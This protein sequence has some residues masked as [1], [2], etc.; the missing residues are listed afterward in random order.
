MRPLKNLLQSHLLG[1]EYY[2]DRYNL[3][4]GI[5]EKKGGKC[6]SEKYVNVATK[7]EFECKEG[8]VWATTP[9]GIIKGSWC[10]VCGKKKTVEPQKNDF[11]EIK[12]II[13]DKGGKC[14]TD[15]YINSLQKLDVMCKEG[16][17][18][19]ISA[20][21]LKKGSWCV[22]CGIERAKE[23][24]TDSI[25]IYHKIAEEYEGKC[26]S[27]KYVNSRTK[28]KFECKN[29]HVWEAEPHHIKRNHWCKLC[30]NDN[31]KGR[32]ITFQKRYSMEEV[33]EIAVS[34]GGKCLSEKV[35]D[36][37]LDFICKEGHKWST[38]PYLILKGH[39]CPKCAVNVSARKNS[40]RLENFIMM[41]E[42]MGGQCL[43]T[44]YKNNRTVLKYKCGKGHIFESEA[45][46]IVRG[47]WCPACG[48]E[49]AKRKLTGSFDEI[50]DIA[51]KRGGKCLSTEY[52]NNYTRLVF[53]CE[54][55]HVWEAEPKRI[56]AGHWCRKCH[57]MKHR[58]DYLDR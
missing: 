19:K 31:M 18:F 14:F 17:K 52:V 55:G 53:Q 46:N 41:A 33:K 22:K 54:N 47:S 6:L 4:C 56:K 8:H 21:S 45:R 25:D 51:A 12:R 2:R 1:K 20:S 38:T 36:H 13:T 35:I 24:T 34:K 28:L 39:W 27:D 48:A 42:K 10:P 40:D 15:E 57:T 32:V 44:E 29:G 9:R 11:N 7:M 5:A 26:L 16:H 50:K 43:S 58:E 30:A 3:M 37:K 49:S 23:K